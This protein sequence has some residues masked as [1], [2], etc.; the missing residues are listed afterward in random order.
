MLQLCSW[1]YAW[2]TFDGL[3]RRASSRSSVK[4]TRIAMGVSGKR[5]HEHDIIGDLQG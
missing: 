2:R 5:V 4:H 1:N 3:K